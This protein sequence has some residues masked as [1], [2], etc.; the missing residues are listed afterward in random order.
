MEEKNRI[1]NPAL[2]SLGHSAMLRVGGV[3]GL[4]APQKWS[5]HTKEGFLAARVLGAL[6]VGCSAHLHPALPNKA[7]AESWPSDLANKDVSG[8]QGGDDPLLSSHAWEA[9]ANDTSFWRAWTVERHT[10]YR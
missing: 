3:S 2:V 9:E 8:A 1:N 7:L 5:R 10:V 4:M 6:S